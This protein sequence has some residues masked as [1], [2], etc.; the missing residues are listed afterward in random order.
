M[1]EKEYHWGGQGGR[2]DPTATCRSTVP[3]GRA[4]TV[5]R[6]PAGVG[7]ARSTGNREGE[8]QSHPEDREW[9]WGARGG[10]TRYEDFLPV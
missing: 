9:K 2:A 3:S 4:A 10:G 1:Q 5:N 7:L 6:L 8:P